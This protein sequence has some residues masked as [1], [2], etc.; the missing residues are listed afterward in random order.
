MFG[1]FLPLKK[2]EPLTV[3]HLN[4]PFT[5]NKVRDMPLETDPLTSVATQP[6]ASP[7]AAPQAESSVDS[8]DLSSMFSAA[9][10]AGSESAAPVNATEPQVAPGISALASQAAQLGIQLPATASDADVATALMARYQQMAPMAQY[11]Q[12]LLPHANEINEYFASKGQAA[13]QPAAPVKPEE[14]SVD[15]HFQKHWDG[16]KLTQ[17][18]QF[19]INQGMVVRDPESGMMMPKPGMELMVAPI[20]QGMN[21]AL[22]WRNEAA[23][24]FIEDPFRKSWTVLQEPIE[25]LIQQRFQAYQQAQQQQYQAVQ[26]QQTA[27][28]SVNSFEVANKDWIYQPANNGGV[29]LTPKG[30]QFV[31]LVKE[32]S[33]N[34]T[35]DANLL[36]HVCKQAVNGVEPAAN[37]AGNGEV[38]AQSNP[39]PG[40]GPIQSTAAQVSGVKK[41][42][43]LQNAINNAAHQPS[44]GANTVQSPNGPVTVTPM[45]LENMFVNDFRAASAAV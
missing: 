6:S 39:S 3:P 26:S 27:A 23:R 20:L 45:E 18:M 7:V 33:G 11:A 5:L 24:G 16:P 21:S 9:Q 32:L 36:L 31:R 28:D 12:S 25:R 4:T 15:G 1:E 22:N 34:F 40:S 42:S 37:P 43:F 41:T 44:G 13:A 8:G 2:E 38:A 29:L 14:W 35:G 30:Q 10:V 17:E 19:A